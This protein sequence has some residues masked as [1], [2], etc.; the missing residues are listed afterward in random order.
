M[1]S[2]AEEGSDLISREQSADLARQWARRA[3]TGMVQASGGRTVT[4]PMFRGR[5]DLD[6]TVTDV[7][8][9]AGL[10]AAASL[11]HAAWRLALEYVRQA[12][13]AGNSW[14][15]IGV[16]LGFGLLAESDMSVAGAAH[17][18][19]AGGPETWSR[20]F[21][22]VCPACQT[23]VIDFGPEAGN[24]DDQ[25]QGHAADWPPPGR[26][27]HRL[28]CLLGDGGRAVTANAKRYRARRHGHQKTWPKRRAPIARL[29]NSSWA[30]SR[31][32]A[33]EGTAGCAQANQP[34]PATR[35]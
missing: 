35:F 9:L 15:D 4:R 10:Q 3:V 11:K 20:S 19:A 18:Y 25:E 12:R 34:L 14:H 5:S 29:R 22:W 7:E 1:L 23:T 24:P 31:T 6:S 16:A 33:R 32:R 8:P 17:D 26:G 13:E 2:V 27:T 30:R 21:P 28:G